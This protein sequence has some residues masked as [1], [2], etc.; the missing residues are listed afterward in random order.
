MRLRG[1]HIRL[2]RLGAQ[3]RR[4]S[5]IIDDGIGKISSIYRW[6]AFIA[7]IAGMDDVVRFGVA[8]ELIQVTQM[9]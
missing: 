4:L 7:K 5:K 3:L 8:G 6:L 2:R 9:S 1:V